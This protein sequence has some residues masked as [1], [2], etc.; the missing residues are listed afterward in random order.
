MDTYKLKVRAC[1]KIFHTNR[2]KKES[3][4]SNIYIRKQIDFK[5]KTIT[6]DNEGQYLMINGS[7]QEDITAI[8]IYAPNIGAPQYTWNMLTTIN[9]ELGSNKIIVG[10]FN[11]HSHQWTHHLERKLINK[12]KLK[13]IH[14]T[15]LTH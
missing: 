5:I 11:T 12:H 3:E 2:N 15:S 6:R 10:D 4:N 1:E 8:N 13:I 7:I 9:G 14:W